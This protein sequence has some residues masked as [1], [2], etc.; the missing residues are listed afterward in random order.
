MIVLGSNYRASGPPVYLPITEAAADADTFVC[1]FLGGSAANETG[2]GLGL[3]GADLVLTQVG[4]VAASSSSYRALNGSGQYFTG[5]AT[6]AAAF[7]NQAEWTYAIKFK[8]LTQ[9]A[10]RRLFD[11]VSGVQQAMSY[12]TTSAFFPSAQI[13]TSG[14]G[15]LVGSALP[16]TASATWLCAWRKGGNIHIGWKT[17]EA[18][19]TG[20]DDFPANQRGVVGSYP[21][22][23]G[24]WTTLNAVASNT[25][26]AAFSIGV[27]VASKIGLTSAPV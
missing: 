11:F 13:N 20:W 10:G 24:T 5:T 7:L 18:L 23:S 22:F 25:N 2:V 21:V 12:L 3:A 6:F 26:P 19:P 8:S 14:G 15:P 27:V 4:S 9:T 1:E 17:Q 16:A